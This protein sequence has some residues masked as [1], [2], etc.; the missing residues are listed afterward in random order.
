VISVAAWHFA[1]AVLVCA[2]ALAAAVF[3]VIRFAYS[4]EIANL[5]SENRA[6]QTNLRFAKDQRD[7][8]GI[9]VQRPTTEIAKLQTQQKTGATLEQQAATTSSVASSVMN[10]VKLSNQL[11]K[12]LA[13]EPG[14]EYSGTPLPSRKL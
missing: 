7:A 13:I 14:R 6:V 11:G 12:T 9:E 4:R 1:V 10:I 5:K 2:T 8:L 3:F